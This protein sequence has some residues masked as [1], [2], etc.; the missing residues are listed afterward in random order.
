V[1]PVTGDR[2]VGRKSE[3]HRILNALTTSFTITGARTIGKTS[4]L[5]TIR[6]QVNTGPAR[7]I[8]LAVFVDATQD[9]RLRG[10]QRNL[11]QA[12]SREA[13][14]R[15][16]DVDWIDPGHDFFE[17]LSTVIRKSARQYLFLIDEVDNLIQD[18]KFA[19]FEEIVRTLSNI[20]CARFVLSG[21]KTLRERTMNRESFFFNL[22]ESITLSPLVRAEALELVRSQMDRVFVGFESD[23]VVE[24]ILELGS[25]FAAYL[26]HMCHLLLKRLDESGRDRIIRLE[27]VRAV[28]DGEEF[29]SAITSAVTASL[30]QT[31]ALLERLIL[32]WAAASEHL[33]F[34]ERELLEGLSKYLYAP[35]QT[36]VLRALEY[37]TATYLLAQSGGKYYFCMPHLREKLSNTKE[38]MEFTIAS[39]ARE[40]REFGA[41]AL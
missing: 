27:D 8:T 14:Q 41:R 34:S 13:E 17:N 1:G 40:Y 10:F 35:R 12:L 20:G 4:L 33:A 11:M 22:F 36:E 39:L 3:L 32:Y 23:L 21:Y 31:S 24:S 2:F 18:S 38:D 5:H 25:T 28:Y 15:G 6:D 30:G 7:N 37:L 19:E 26:Q 16:V 9:H 29:T